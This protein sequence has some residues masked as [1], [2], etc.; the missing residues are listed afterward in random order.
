M[1]YLRNILAIILSAL[2]FHLGTGM[3][4]VHVCS[5]IC[6]DVCH[7]DEG[8]VAEACTGHCCRPLDCDDQGCDSS[9]TH[10]HQGC[11]CVDYTFQS[12]FFFTGVHSWVGELYPVVIPQQLLLQQ[13]KALH[14][15]YSRVLPPDDSPLSGR[16]ILS[17]HDILRL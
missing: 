5:H 14:P 4:L 3:A 17:L 12:D 11:G 16:A 13:P 2:V 15:V 8:L 1:K 9:E 7:T 6:D 10:L